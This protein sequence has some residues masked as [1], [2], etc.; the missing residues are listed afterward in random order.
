VAFNDRYNNN[1]LVPKAGTKRGYTETEVTELRKCVS[2]PVY[3]AKTYFKIVSLDH[4]LINFSLYDYQEDAIRLFREKRNLI[5]NAS[6]QSGKTSIATVILLHTALYNDNKL[7]AILANKG[8]TAREILDRVKR[9]YEYLPDFLKP[10]VKVWNKGSV[11]FENGSKIITS[12]SSADNLRG[13]A[14]FLLYIDEMA[15]ISNWEDFSASVLPTLSSGQSTKMILTSTPNGLNHYYNYVESARKNPD[16]EFG[17]IEVPWYRVPGRD[18]AWRQRT[19][20]ELNYDEQKFDV[21]FCCQFMGSSATLISGGNLQLL[22]KSKPL[23][24]DRHIFQYEQVKENHIYMI[25][26]DVSRGKGLDYSAFSVIDITSIPYQQVL[27]YRNNLITPTDYADIL[28]RIAYAYNEAAILIELND[29]GQQVSDCLYDNEYPNILSTQI[30][31]RQGKKLTT[32]LVKKNDRGI[33]MTKPVKATGCATLKLLIEQNKLLIHDQNTISEFTTF[34]RDGNTYKAESGKHDDLVMG[35]VIFAWATVQPFFKNL[36]DSD[37]LAALR[38]KTAEEIDE[39][40]LPLCII[41]DGR[42]EY[43]EEAVEMPDFSW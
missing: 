38:E 31:G 21:E 19:L 29:L 18:E 23:N 16:G 20:A 12:A 43:M 14:I 25:V 5:I 39:E 9:A 1:P 36:Y 7:I 41:D 10:G 2:D 13:S 27:V 3:L 24:N 15:Y 8:A 30:K 6:R 22:E 34:S 28:E 33:R 40:M 17:L 26:V 4:G 42:D 35:L 11:E 32:S 37:I